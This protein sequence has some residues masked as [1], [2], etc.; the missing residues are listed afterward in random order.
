MLPKPRSV[1]HIESSSIQ[2][3]SKGV[4]FLPVSLGSLIYSCLK[5]GQW[6]YLLHRVVGIP[7][8]LRLI[9]ITPDL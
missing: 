3:R 6:Q 1:F 9:L 8:K 7:M 4:H 5:W 2:R